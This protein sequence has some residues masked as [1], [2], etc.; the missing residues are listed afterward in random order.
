TALSGI[1]PPR[2]LLLV[3]AFK[4]GPQP[5]LDVACTDGLNLAQFTRE[6]HLARLANQ[7]ITRVVVGHAK[8][9]ARTIDS[10][11][12]LFSL[13]QVERERLVAHDIE[14]RLYRGLGNFK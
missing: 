10:F 13:R 4:P 3:V 6:N 8:D 7:G 11:G 1:G 14:A 5:S 9:H 12:Q 2:G